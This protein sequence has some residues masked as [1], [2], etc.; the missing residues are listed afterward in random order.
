[1]ATEKDAKKKQRTSSDN[2]TTNRDDQSGTN[3]YRIH[4]QDQN[5]QTTD[6]SHMTLFSRP[7]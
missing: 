6:E 3:T 1:M 7:N 4:D 2:A 5:N